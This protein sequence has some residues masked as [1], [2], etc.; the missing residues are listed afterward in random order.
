MHEQANYLFTAMEL[1]MGW[2]C[3]EESIYAPPKPFHPNNLP[4]LSQ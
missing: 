2:G 1:R 3:S 4:Q